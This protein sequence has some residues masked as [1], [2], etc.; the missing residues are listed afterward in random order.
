MNDWKTDMDK[1]MAWTT[2]NWEK[3]G[4]RTFSAGVTGSL[5]L[6]P[7]EIEEKPKV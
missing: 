6:G 2:K 4:K 3:T 7:K 1:L 5:D